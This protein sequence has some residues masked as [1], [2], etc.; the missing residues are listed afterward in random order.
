MSS[1][2]NEV[3]NKDGGARNTTAPEKPKLD[4]SLFLLSKNSMV[5]DTVISKEDAAKM[6]KIINETQVST[7]SHG[8]KL[9]LDRLVDIT[10]SILL[11]YKNTVDVDEKYKRLMREGLDMLYTSTL[12]RIKKGIDQL[13]LMYIPPHKGFVEHPE[14]I[15]EVHAPITAK[16]I[17][18]P[19]PVPEN[20]IPQPKMSRTTRT[21]L[22]KLAKSVTTNN[23][24]FDKLVG[25]A[26]P[27][28]SETPKAA[29]DG[30]KTS[31]GKSK[32]AK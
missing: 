6:E 25:K 27:E 26:E 21:K 31:K 5:G 8:I 2:T 32:K 12:S 17:S 22:N 18:V 10:N 16:P 9:T 19:V 28:K 29:A 14:N 15:K 23:K 11:T 13:L 4:E 30:K 20:P 7:P 1:E 3:V 24:F